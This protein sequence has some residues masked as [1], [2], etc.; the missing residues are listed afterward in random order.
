MIYPVSNI[1][2]QDHS[3]NLPESAPDIREASRPH[4]EPVFVA[5]YCWE[6]REKHDQYAINSR[7]EDIFSYEDP[8]WYLKAYT[9]P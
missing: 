3:C 2:T 9:A 4:A 5:K 8:K 7:K 6:G 1:T